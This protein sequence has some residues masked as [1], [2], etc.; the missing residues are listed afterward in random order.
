MEDWTSCDACLFIFCVLF[1][2]G[3]VFEER[4][5]MGYNNKRYE[6]SF[7]MKMQLR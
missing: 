3:K 4:N 5:L 2:F 1:I 6:H 7:N